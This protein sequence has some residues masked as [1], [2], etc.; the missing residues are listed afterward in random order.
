M[1]SF[2]SL[3]FSKNLTTFG[4]DSDICFILIGRVL[5]PLMNS[6]ELNGDKTL[7]INLNSLLLIESIILL[8]LQITPPIAFACPPI[9]FV[10]E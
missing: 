1:T 2:T 10:A 6:H 5:K 4:V 7:P 9:Y 8:E 3:F